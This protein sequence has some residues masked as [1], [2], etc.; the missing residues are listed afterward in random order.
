MLNT[1]LESTN[2]YFC[3]E[4]KLAGF[5]AVA[6]SAVGLNLENDRSERGKHGFLKTNP[7][8]KTVGVTETILSWC[9]LGRGRQVLLG[10]NEGRW[11]QVERK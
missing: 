7:K 9:V 10:G 11:E 6:T 4:R 2:F 3:Q 8:H 5:L 1:E